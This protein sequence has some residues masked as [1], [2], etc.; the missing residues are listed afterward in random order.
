MLMKAW[1]IFK[2]GEA[3]WGWAFFFKAFRML[4]NQHQSKG[5][6]PSL[7]FLITY[8]QQ[9]AASQAEIFTMSYGNS[10]WMLKF[11]K[12]I[13]QKRLQNLQPWRIIH[14]DAGKGL[15]CQTDGGRIYEWM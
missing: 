4:T 3:F 9:A 11:L 8:T 10:G 12:V 13:L 7:Y 6:T 15:L 14:T 1:E 5:A 2:H